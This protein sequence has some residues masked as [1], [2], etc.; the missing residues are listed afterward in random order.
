MMQDN[1]DRVQIGPVQVGAYLDQQQ[2]LETIVNDQGQIFAGSAIA[3][4]P[5]KVMTARQDQAVA[6]MLQ[7]AEIRYADG[8]GV[9]VVMRLRLKRAIQRIPGCELWQAL[10]LRCARF[11]VPVYLVGAKPQ[12]LAQTKD[13]LLQQ[14]VDVVGATDGYFNDE[15]QVIESIRQS[16][17][18]VISV[19]MGSPKQEQF[20]DRCKKQLPACFFMGVG[21]SYDVFTGNVKRAPALW[22]KLHL[23]WAYRLV[24]QPSRLGRQGKLFHYLWLVLRGRL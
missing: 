19:A 3:I 21:G 11:Q 8:I 4:N 17:A 23:E 1:V 13:K 18:Q 9:V 6:Q 5:E 24:S 14:Q 15:Q 10:M 16:G 2:L 7:Q 20:I 22:C 12:V